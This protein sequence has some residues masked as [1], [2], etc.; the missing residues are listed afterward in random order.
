[1][2]LYILIYNGIYSYLYVL[3]IIFNSQMAQYQKD[4]K[5]RRF[6]D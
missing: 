4:R 5:D 3:E 1:V 2:I 6:V